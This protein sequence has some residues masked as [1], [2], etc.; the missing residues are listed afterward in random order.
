MSVD[1]ELW[2]AVRYALTSHKLAHGSGSARGS[3]GLFLFDGNLG[4]F[5]YRKYAITLFKVHSLDR[6][7]CNDRGHFSRSSSN[8]EF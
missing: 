2:G 7:S 5:D 4:R 6:A 1:C 8:D 3:E